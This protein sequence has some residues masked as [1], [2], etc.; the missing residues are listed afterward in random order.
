VA[1]PLIALLAEQV[2]GAG[3]EALGLALSGAGGVLATI[4]GLSLL[5]V[6][7]QLRRKDPSLVRVAAA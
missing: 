5:M 6:S 4:G 1:P 7:W 2:F 3:Q